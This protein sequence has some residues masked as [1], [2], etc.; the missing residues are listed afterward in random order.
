[1]LLGPLFLSSNIFSGG[2]FCVLCLLSLLQIPVRFFRACGV[3]EGLPGGCEAELSVNRRP[4]DP[5]GHPT[6]LI[7][8]SLNLIGARQVY[9]TLQER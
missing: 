4:C 8:Q 9:Q 2:Y 1:M 3:W 7:R 5:A 6:Q